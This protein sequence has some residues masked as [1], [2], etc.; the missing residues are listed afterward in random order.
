MEESVNARLDRV[1]RH[2][3]EQIALFFRMLGEAIEKHPR[4]LPDTALQSVFE[5][6]RAA[7]EGRQFAGPP[8]KRDRAAAGSRRNA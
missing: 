7:L 3:P 4:G 6:H 8:T 5:Q 2:K 1:R